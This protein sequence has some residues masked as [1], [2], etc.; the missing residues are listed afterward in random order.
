MLALTVV[1]LLLPGTAFVDTL[2]TG[3]A[4]SVVDVETARWRDAVA[5]PAR[6][7]RAVRR[8]LGRGA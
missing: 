3:R 2:V 5:A 1:G 4:V 7:R 6:R 8:R